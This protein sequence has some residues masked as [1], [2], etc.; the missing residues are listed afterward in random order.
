MTSQMFD[1]VRC[2][3][4]RTGV[5]DLGTVEVT[6]RYADCSMWRTPCCNQLVDDRGETGWKSQKDYVKLSQ[7]ELEM[8][9][10]RTLDIYGHYRGRGGAR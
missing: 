6:A 3:R 10:K 4:C 7:A 9:R 5:Y 8:H 1:P 2:N